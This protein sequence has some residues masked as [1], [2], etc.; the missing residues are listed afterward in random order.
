ME[1]LSCCALLL[2]VSHIGACATSSINASYQGPNYA[3]TGNYLVEGCAGSEIQI[4]RP[5]ELSGT[6]DFA[7][8][9]M[10]SAT[11]AVDVNA[12]VMSWTMAA[13]QSMLQI[14][15]Q[16]V[17]DAI[18][19]NSEWLDLSITCAQDVEFNFSISIEIRDIQPL[20][21]A[22]QPLNIY[23]DQDALLGLDISGGSGGYTVEW[24]SQFTGNPY[25][26]IDPE[27]G[28]IAYTV[29]D[30]CSAVPIATGAAEIAF[31]PYPIISVSAGLDITLNCT[32]DLSIAIEPTGGNGIYT[33]QWFINGNL[34]AA[35]SDETFL[36]TGP[37]TSTISVV[38]TDE[39][40]HA[41]VDE[42]NVVLYNPPPTINIGSTISGNCLELETVVATISGGL[43]QSDVTWYYNDVPIGEGNAIELPIAA[44]GL[45]QAQAQDGCGSIG[46]ASVDVIQVPVQLEV[47][48]DPIFGMCESELPATAQI[49]GG[50]GDNF[51]YEWTI[52]GEII[53]TADNAVVT[54]LP[55]EIVQL[56][57]TDV[58]GNTDEH[59]I[60]I[61]LDV[62][63]I[64]VQALENIVASNCDELWN[65]TSPI[66]TGGTG[67][68][69]YNWHLSGESETLSTSANWQVDVMGL[70]NLWLVIE[71]TDECTNHGQDSTLV[72]L[73]LTQISTIIDTEYSFGCTEDFQLQPIITGGALP[74]SYSWTT[75]GTTIGEGATYESQAVTTEELVLVV[76]DHCGLTDE[77]AIH[78]QVEPTNL[79]AI[80]I[81]DDETL[82]PQQEVN[83]M[84]STEN[85]IGDLSVQ[86]ST[87]QSDETITHRVDAE[88]VIVCTVEDVCGNSYAANYT[89]ELIPTDG[90]LMV[91]ENF[92]L[93]HGHESGQLAF[94]GYLPYSYAYTSDAIAASENGVIAMR[95]SEVLV[96]VTDACGQSDHVTVDSRSCDF[97][98]PNVFT[99]NNDSKNDTF[100]I[101]GL[102]K[103]PK[104]TLVVFDRDGNKV[105]ETNDYKNDWR[106]DGLPSGTYFFVL[107]R[108]D[109]ELFE[110]SVAILR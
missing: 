88:Q 66:L 99:P 31:I 87:G 77:T 95:T 33:I 70:H 39:C 41:G 35:N 9:C 51:Q 13:E 58:C 54:A 48:I 34:N 5:P 84:V 97:I 40:N 43:G 67:N 100:E 83:L 44:G 72:Q 26:V 29:T 30:L 96:V 47:L 65:V 86:W 74:Y 93:C 52:Q 60:P 11:E 3:I 108:N 56:V 24:A 71:V 75:N 109:G 21:V 92:V 15:I 49:T 27:P 42:M 17:S 79:T 106:A 37:V 45:L 6:I 50:V 61:M 53:S 82:C 89:L 36:W 103:F 20:V 38:V 80:I 28:T 2:L 94:G 91:L 7:V 46:T 4:V 110:S 55:N 64:S 19:E 63:N 73:A 10:G 59:E 85:Q 1:K 25:L 23:C 62:Q 22:Q 57:V 76:M 78:I 8:Q 81:A 101:N 18:I 68:F 102:E 69:N 32:E 105:F 98:L 12:L 16:A 90:P 104:S 14:P 107:R